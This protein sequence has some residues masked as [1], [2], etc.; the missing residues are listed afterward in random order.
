[1]SI[2]KKI[3]ALLTCIVLASSVMLVGC[4]TTS[5]LPEGAKLIKE[6]TLI[7]GSDCDYPPFIEMNWMNKPIGFEYEL[8]NLIG[9]NLGVKI[10]YL[11]PQNFDTLIATVAAGGV[12]DVGVSSFTITPDRLK[13]VDFCIPYFNSNQAIV[14]LKT[15]NLTNYSQLA[16]KV[17]G[18]QSGTTGEEW[19]RENLPTAT[20]KPFNQTSEALLAL[21]AG[22]IYAAIYDEPVAKKHMSGNTWTQCE[23][24]QVIAT[25]EQYGFAVAKDNPELRDALNQALRDLKKDGSFD[26]LFAKYFPGVDPPSLK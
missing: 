15:S 2:T 25:N 10:K 3:I 19:A 18:V 24:V 21:A 13:E 9:K 11:P 17:I 1:M 23:L 14:A 22:D 8:M 5:N 16:G 12:M 7:I 26:K 6:G 4:K 20:I